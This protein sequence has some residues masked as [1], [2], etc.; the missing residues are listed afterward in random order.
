MNTNPAWFYNEIQHDEHSTFD[1]V[2]ESL[3]ERAGFQIDTAEYGEG[4]GATYIC[5]RL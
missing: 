4:L 5:T 1:W 3:L 2:I